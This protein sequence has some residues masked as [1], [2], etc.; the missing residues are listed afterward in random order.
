MLIVFGLGANRRKS[1]K[2]IYEFFSCQAGLSD[3]S[4]KRT[5]R[6]VSSR[7]VRYNSSSVSFRV[8]PNFM[9][10]FSVPV[11][12]KTCFTKLAY[13]FGWFK[14]WKAAHVSTGTGI[15]TFNLKCGL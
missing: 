10:A 12:H 3:N 8:V 7:V 4:T 9:A 2:K 1:L 11:K 6:N 15:F 13:Y 14:R 5:F